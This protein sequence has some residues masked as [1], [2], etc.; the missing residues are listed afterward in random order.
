MAWLVTQNCKILHVYAPVN[1]YNISL[2]NE[3]G[4]KHSRFTCLDV[5]DPLCFK[6]SLVQ[7]GAL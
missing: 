3:N 2:K 6:T 7:K 4:V 5:D 1:Q